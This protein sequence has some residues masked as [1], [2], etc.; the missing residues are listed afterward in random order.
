MKAEEL[1]KK[2]CIEKNIDENTPYEAWGFCGGEDG[3]DELL[4][5]VLEGKK[6][7]TAS[8]YEDYLSEGDEIPGD[9]EYSVL[10]NS[11]EEA[12][13]VIRNFE[14]KVEP[15][16][17]V[18]EYHGY[19]EGEEERNLEAWRRIHDNYWQEDFNRLNI[20][21]AKECHAV[22][23]KFTVEYLAPGV[24]G[25][26]GLLEDF[27]LI[28]PN[29]RYADAIAQFRKDMLDA[30]SSMDGC[31]SLAR[32]EDPNEWIFFSYEKGNPMK[33]FAAD[34]ITGTLLMC[35]RKSDDKIVGMCHIR[36]FDE[37]HPL[38]FCGN[39]GY[40]VHPAERR[41][42]YATWILRKSLEYLKYGMNCSVA[43]IAALPENEA[44]IKTITKC[45]GVYKNSCIDFRC[46]NKVNRY[47][48]DLKDY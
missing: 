48:I 37:K 30:G 27:F 17:R 1:W 19:S 46:G 13:A 25:K 21:S 29:E 8:I 34:E 5:L 33:E 23:E 36:N 14:V 12:I 38:K 16:Y 47:V 41:K 15:F 40:S 39:I 31:M 9:R 32:I 44:S 7:G 45:G 6:F 28:E 22:E 42:G 43:E 20:S 24:K 2:F 26:E 35:V 10:L 18:S 4:E 3:C 11:K